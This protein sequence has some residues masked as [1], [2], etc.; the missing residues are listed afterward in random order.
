MRAIDTPTVE[1]IS[2]SGLNGNHA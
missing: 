1:D 2:A